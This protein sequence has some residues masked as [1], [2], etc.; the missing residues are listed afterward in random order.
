MTDTRK[1]MTDTRNKGLRECH[2]TVGILW[3][4]LN[5]YSET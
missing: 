5:E 1:K 2:N 4:I 3:H